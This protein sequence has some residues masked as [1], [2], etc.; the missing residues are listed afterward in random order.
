MQ[1]RNAS[2]S[3]GLVSKLLHWIMA[4]GVVIAAIVAKVSEDLSSSRDRYEWMVNHKSIGLTLL[5]LL[6]LRLAWRLSNPS[7]EFPATMP[8]WQRLAARITHWALYVLLLWMPITGWLAHSASGIPLKW[9]NWFKVPR[10]AD[11][12]TELKQL[13]EQMHDWG[14]WL[15]FFLFIAHVAAALKHHV[16]DR[17]DTLR[18]MW[19][20][21]ARANRQSE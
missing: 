18:R 19:F 12:D 2:D 1:V 13:A 6:L 7:P 11:K 10:L 8:R 4:V 5:A 21:S 20:S 15:L 16:L 3:W 14:V 17:D 9:F